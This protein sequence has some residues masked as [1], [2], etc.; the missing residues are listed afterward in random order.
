VALVALLLLAAEP[1]LGQCRMCRAALETPETAALA[2]SFRRAI[3]FLLA[4]P[5]L[6]V[7]VVALLVVRAHRASAA[8][9]APPADG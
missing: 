8:A 1:A 2:H 4:A 9:P 5:F 6:A 3:V 7:G